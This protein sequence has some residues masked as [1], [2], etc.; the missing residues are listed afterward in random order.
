MAIKNILDSVAYESIKK[1]I[2]NLQPNAERVWGKMDSA[3]MLAHC[4][5]PIE[6]AIGKTP[7]VDESNFLS[8]TL[9]RWVVLRKIKQGAFGRNLPTA[10]S[11]YITDER[12]FALEKQRLLAN[13]SH[14]FEKGQKG[15]FM[16]HPSFGNFSAKQWGELTHLHLDHHLS[17]FS[18]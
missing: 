8:K 1:R 4:S 16:P 14:F 10:K 12:L 13:L 17:Q 15:S 6:Q 11:F 9:I 7:F 2:E 3:Q 18:A 5:V